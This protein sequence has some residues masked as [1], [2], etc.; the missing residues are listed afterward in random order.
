MPIEIIKHGAGYHVTLSPPEGP[1]WRSD[2]IMTA[3]EVL[4]RLSSLGCHST[5][6]TDA[7]HAAD[8]AWSMLHDEEVLRRRSRH[9]PDE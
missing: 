8:P 4:A 1:L 5:D 2:A 3:T 6:I 9:G 7:I